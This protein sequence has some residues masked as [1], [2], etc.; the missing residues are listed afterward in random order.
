MTISLT[1]CKALGL[2]EKGDD[3]FVERPG[4]FRQK[5]EK[6]HPYDRVSDVCHLHKSISIDINTPNIIGNL[7]NM[8]S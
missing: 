4:F 3:W 2:V 6:K 5:D 7:F 8:F 1:I